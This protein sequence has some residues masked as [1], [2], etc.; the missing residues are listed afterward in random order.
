MKP[1]A[2]EF[3]K[4]NTGDFIPGVLT[5]IK[6]DMEHE[7]SY[8]G[9][10]SISP[11]VKLIFQLE[12]YKDPKPSGWLKF[13]YADKSNLYKKYVSALVEGAKP[14]MDFDLEQL[15]GIKVK[16][17][18]KDSDDGKYQNIDTIRPVGAKIKVDP[19]FVPKEADEETVPF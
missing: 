9:T 13:M 14:F 1:E 2:R 7:F 8:K 15:K 6:Y 19:K 18:Y 17:L 10:K 4:V 5:D 3:E 11:G 12:G 16:I